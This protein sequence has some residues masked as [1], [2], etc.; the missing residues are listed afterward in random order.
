MSVFRI[1]KT[2]NYTVMSNH[3]FQEKNM[4]LKAKGLLSLMLSLPDDWD[5]SIA[6]L[7]CICA[8]NETAI[9]T[10]LAELEQ[11]GYLT[12]TKM[13]PNETKSGRIEYLYC[14]YEKSQLGQKQDSKKQAVENLVVENLAVENHSQLNTKQV[15]T[16]KENLES[17][18]SRLEKNQNPLLSVNTRKERQTKK[19]RDVLTIKAMTNS[20][21]ENDELLAR[22]KVYQDLRLKKG[23]VPEQWQI[24]L[25]DLKTTYGKSV[26]DSVRMVD[27][28]I[29]GGYMQIVPIWDKNRA[30]SK[31]NFDNTAGRQSKAVATMT[32]AEVEDFERTLA[33]DKNGRPL[34]F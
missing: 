6:G 7:V 14:V 4:S 11:F 34:S 5:Y 15:N 3:H 16:K 18:D 20:F 32:A 23:L 30:A 31:K 28:A 2:S 9:K 12:V 17:K 24:I 21:T 8:E 10:A 27:N 13:F 26:Q 25:S 19:A 33:R 29:A 1:E 22:L